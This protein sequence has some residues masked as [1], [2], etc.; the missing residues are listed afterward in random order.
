M[1]IFV[2]SLSGVIIYWS[3]LVI[4]DPSQLTFD[5]TSPSLALQVSKRNIFQKIFYVHSANIGEQHGLF[6]VFINKSFT[7]N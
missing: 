2:I 4:E 6:R 5:A 3:D 1:Q 7:C